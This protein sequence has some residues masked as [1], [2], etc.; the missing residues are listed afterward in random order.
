MHV[1]HKHACT[2]ARKRNSY[3]AA[4]TVRSTAAVYP[5]ILDHEAAS[6]PGHALQV[7][8]QRKLAS[9]LSACRSAGVD[10]IPV[11]A[12][13]LGG[14]AEDTISTIRSLR[15]AIA[16]RVNP[17]D[18]STCVKQLFHRVAIALWRGNACLWLHR[19]PTLPPSVDGVVYFTF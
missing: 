6:T 8:V 9:H 12:E 3:R 17:Q 7:G 1:K 4:Q 19:Q 15:E 2:R 18:S 11:V 16:Q 5:G 14:L 13:T 10:F